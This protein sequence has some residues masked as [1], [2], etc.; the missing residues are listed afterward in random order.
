MEKR[1]TIHKVVDMLEISP[2]S[3]KSFLKGDLKTGQL[4][5]KFCSLP[6]ER[7][8]EGETRQHM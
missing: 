6:A 4:A 3:V 8:A 5:A 1:I 7:G 2:G